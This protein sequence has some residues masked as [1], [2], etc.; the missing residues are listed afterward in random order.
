MSSWQKTSK[1]SRLRVSVSSS[2]ALR[3]RVVETIRAGPR[4]SSTGGGVILLGNEGS[5]SVLT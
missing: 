1:R 4:K 2:R 3:R 5:V